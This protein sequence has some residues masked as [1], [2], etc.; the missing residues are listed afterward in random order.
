MKEIAK[1]SGVFVMIIGVLVLAIPFF[2]GTTNNTNLL[3]GLLLVIEGFLGH[4]YVNNMK[5]ESIVGNIVWA[6]VLLLVPFGLF[7]VMKKMAYE[8]DEFALYN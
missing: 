7:F 1:Y 4:I 2:G 3:I 6:I 8:K 5:K